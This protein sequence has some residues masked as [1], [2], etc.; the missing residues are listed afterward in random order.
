MCWA[1]TKETAVE[2]IIV[3]KVMMRRDGGKRIHAWG[4]TACD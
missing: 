1:G 4:E 3:Y 2:D